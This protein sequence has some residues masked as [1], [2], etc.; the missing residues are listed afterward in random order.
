MTIA[1]YATY[2]VTDQ[3]RNLKF[4]RSKNHFWGLAKIGAKLGFSP[5]SQVWFGCSLVFVSIA[6]DNNLEQFLA[7]S[8]DEIQKKK[9][10]LEAKI[11]FF[12]I[13]SNF[14]H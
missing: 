3:A 8:S 2:L 12:T 13:F 10:K 1:D 11:R 5:F 7:T 14:V 6:Q 4:S 9:R